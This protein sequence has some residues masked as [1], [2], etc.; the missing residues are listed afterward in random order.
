MELENLVSILLPLAVSTAGILWRMEKAASRSDARLLNVEERIRE[1][2]GEL[3]RLVQDQVFEVAMR[4]LQER[5]GSL[6]DRLVRV[7]GKVFNGGN[8]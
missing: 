6:S 5:I 2:R 7:E 8:K 1:L 3:D 4:A